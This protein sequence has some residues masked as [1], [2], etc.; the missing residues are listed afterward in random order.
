MQAAIATATSSAHRG[1]VRRLRAPGEGFWEPATRRILADAGLAPGMRCLDAGCGPG[2]VMRLHRPHGRPGGHVTGLDIDA[3]LGAH[4]LAEL[5]REEGPNFAFVA[6]DLTR[7]DAGAGR[8]LRSRLRARLL[9]LHMT[10]P[11]RARCAASPRCSGRAAG[12]SSW[13]ST[14]PPRRAAGAP[15][16]DRG[17]AIIAG[18]FTAA[19]SMPTRPASGQLCST[20][21]CRCA[22]RPRRRP[23]AADRP[24][25]RDAARR[26]RRAAPRRRA[27][28]TASPSGRDLAPRRRPHAG[29]PAPAD[30]FVR[31]SIMPA[32]GPLSRREQPAT[33][34]ASGR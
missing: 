12:W 26:P 27:P 20:P 18:A 1:R 31:G 16:A 23:R 34:S 30:D 8:A 11:G 7:G 32:P 6:G 5:H 22:E 4:M 13:T 28:M 33:F 21:A 24:S 17:F 3:A 14:Y 9:L 19:A 10:D 25:G 15:G 2:E 29:P